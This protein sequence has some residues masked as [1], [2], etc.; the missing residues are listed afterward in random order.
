LTNNIGGKAIKNSE[1]LDE[2]D[3]TRKKIIDIIRCRV[4]IQY[5]RRKFNKKA[6]TLAKKGKTHPIIKNDV[7]IFGQK[8]GKRKFD[9]PE[10]D[11]KS[12]EEKNEYNIHIYKKDWIRDQWEICSEFCEGQFQGMILRIYTD[13]EIENKLHRHHIY[14]IKVN[15][16][17]NHHVTINKVIKEIK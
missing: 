1:L 14:K 9:L 8:I 10:V 17:F 13:S 5:V 4:E 16:V 3:K 6:D 7:S 2:I 12:L 11:Y 15:E